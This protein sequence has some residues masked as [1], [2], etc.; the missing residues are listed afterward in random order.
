MRRRHAVARTGTSASLAEGNHETTA[1]RNWD[2][3]TYE[4][5]PFDWDKVSSELNG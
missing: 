4:E 1:R 2:P 3:E 5:I